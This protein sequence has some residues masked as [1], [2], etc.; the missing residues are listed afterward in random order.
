LLMHRNSSSGAASD[1][2]SGCSQRSRQV[3]RRCT[4]TGAA[5][6]RVRDGPR[7]FCATLSDA[8]LR[9]PAKGWQ[10]ALRKALIQRKTS[11]ATNQGVV[12]SNPAGRAIR[13]KQ[14]EPLPA[15][16]SILAARLS[17]VLKQGPS[18]GI[19]RSTSRVKTA[20]C[21]ARRTQEYRVSARLFL[22]LAR[23]CSRPKSGGTT[24]CLR[25]AVR[26]RHRP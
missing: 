20:P 7:D 14:L 21:S 18:F 1:V 13:I 11:N 25:A 9:F 17:R 22:R 19:G 12:G 8:S 3:L 4:D 5:R 2:R 26:R 24:T 10:R 16:L 23:G 6:R 15:A